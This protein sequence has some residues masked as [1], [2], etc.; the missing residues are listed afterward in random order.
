[1]STK[2][3]SAVPKQSTAEPEHRPGEQ[4]HSNEGEKSV[5][6]IYAKYDANE[7]SLDDIFDTGDVVESTGLD[8]DMFK[9]E[10]LDKLQGV[11]FAIL[12][13]TFRERIV[14]G[15]YSDFVTLIAV[16]ANENTLLKRRIR[17]Q[18]TELWFP[19]QVFGINDGSTG[20]RRQIVAHLHSK[21]IIKVV[22]D[23]TE[24]VESGK[25]GECTWDAR[26]G[27]WEFRT[28][29]HTIASDKESGSDLM[30]WEFELEKA[31]V[32][33]KGIRISEYKNRYGKNSVTRYFG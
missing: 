2:H 11:P 12:G 29:D 15:K 27:E 3:K 8:L 32:A 6:G 10:K 19:E 33:P 22:K 26:L 14:E 20:I 18:G 1:V 4:V 23:G 24:I 28:G 5:S 16:I 17:Y 25:R 7:I 30:V 31:M 13:G 21:G 9:D